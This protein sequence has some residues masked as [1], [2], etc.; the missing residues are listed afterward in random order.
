MIENDIIMHHT[1]SCSDLVAQLWE[2]AWGHIDKLPCH[3]RMSL[4][5][6]T[7]PTLWKETSDID[8]VKIN[9]SI[10]ISVS[11]DQNV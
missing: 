8:E 1:Q 5:L 11:Q 9:L 4:N 2:A 10:N 6:S 3:S 7:I